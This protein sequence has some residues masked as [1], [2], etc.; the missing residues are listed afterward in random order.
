MI[1]IDFGVSRSKITVTW[2]INYCPLNNLISIKLRD[3]IVVKRTTAYPSGVYCSDSRSSSYF[4]CNAISPGSP[5]GW[6]CT[7][8]QG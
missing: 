8:A 7:L 2:D 1:P 4:I 3:T 6:Y 5:E